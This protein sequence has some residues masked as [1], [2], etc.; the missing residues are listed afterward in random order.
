MKKLLFYTYLILLWLIPVFTGCN[1][2][3]DNNPAPK[4]KTELLTQTSWKFDKATAGL[5]GD[6]TAYIDACYKD[7]IFTFQSS[8]N[9]NVNEA[10]VVCTP[11]TAG[12]FTWS[13]Q[14][15]ETVL[16]VSATLLPTGSNNFNIITLN[17]TNMVLTQNVTLPAP[18]NQTVLVEFTLKH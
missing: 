13:F 11:S 17:E 10:V 12:N 3:D 8:G 7:N 9:G 14:S 16:S 5:Y 6:V 2:D 15:G 1:K 4:T 18:I